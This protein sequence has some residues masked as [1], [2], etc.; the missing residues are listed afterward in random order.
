MCT[1]NNL[2]LNSVFSSTQKQISLLTWTWKYTFQFSDCLNL[3]LYPFRTTFENF[4]SS[5]PA[6]MSP[7]GMDLFPFLWLQQL[8]RF[9]LCQIHAN[10]VFLWGDIPR[11]NTQNYGYFRIFLLPSPF[12]IV[13]FFFFPYTQ[14]SF[15]KE[16]KQRVLEK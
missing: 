14:Y 7:F 3:T 2:H 15:I 4:C 12:S 9:C 1:L 6:F 13:F 10:N 5:S 8:P 16:I 11:V